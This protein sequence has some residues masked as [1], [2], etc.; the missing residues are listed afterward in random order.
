MTHQKGLDHAQE[1][2]F[3]VTHGDYSIDSDAAETIVDA[4]LRASSMVLVPREPTEDMICE[5]AY[6][7]PEIRTTDF[8]QVYS[9]MLSAA[10]DPFR[11][12]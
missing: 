1:Q 2:I 9:I 7:R 12:P 8:V 4:Y 11:N 3:R 10:P 6:Y 5:A